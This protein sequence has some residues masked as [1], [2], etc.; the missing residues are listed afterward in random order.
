[1]IN[2]SYIHANEWDA[3][4]NKKNGDACTYTSA[5]TTGPSGPSTSEISGFCDRAGGVSGSQLFCNRQP[6]G[7]KD[8]FSRSVAGDACEL[9]GQ[10]GVC[11]GDFANTC[12]TTQKPTN[13]PGGSTAATCGTATCTGGQVCVNQGNPPRPTCTANAASSDRCGTA[14]CTGGQ[15]CANQGNP[16]RPT[17]TTDASTPGNSANNGATPGASSPQTV[18]FTNPIRFNSIPELI[19]GIINALLGILGAITVAILVMSGFKY[20]TSSNPGEVGQALDGI[21]NAIVG[22]MIIMGSFLI[23]QY[24]ISALAG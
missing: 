14:T 15:V 8:C 21:R 23:T 17:C 9:N 4:N 10:L 6:N 5:P 11:K 2:I 3:C 20:M 24:V 13:T 7:W 1:M 18:G 19:A 22:L 12:D 16:P